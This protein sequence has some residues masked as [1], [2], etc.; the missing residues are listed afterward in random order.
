MVKTSFTLMMNNSIAYIQFPGSNTENE[1]INMIKKCGMTPH[2][3]FWNDNPEDL[4]KYSGYIILGG[5]SFEDRSR[6]GIIASLEPVMDE[7]KKQAQTGKPV[8]G[9]CNGAQILV[10]S[11]MVPGNNNFDTVI[12]LADN[13]RVVRNNI[14]GT[15]YYNTWCYI[16]PN[17]KAN[18][19]FTKSGGDILRVPIAHAEGRF[20]LDKD[21]SDLVMNKNLTTYQYC[22]ENGEVVGDFPVNPNGSFNNAAAISNLSGNVMAMMPH[23][24]RTINGEGNY[25]F[26]NLK[27]YINS[28]EKLSYKSLNF[29]SKKIKV[30]KF[31]QPEDS[32]EVLIST[33]I[34]DNEAL[35]VE[36]CINMLG[37]NVKI[38]KYLHYE[39]IGVSEKEL[40]K[41][42]E[43]DVL[44]NPSKE[45]V[46]NIKRTSS[47][48]HFISRSHDDIHG[49]SLLQTLQTRFSFE[50]LSSLK[51]GVVWEIDFSGDIRKKDV[52]LILNSHI[53]ANPISQV[54]HE[55]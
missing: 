54:C 41:V 51:S 7:I 25:I 29:E 28:S 49:Q 23:P 20:M 11:G 35:S 31:E 3:H 1:T 12:A 30:G 45:F 16:K 55:Y 17:P 39:V 15:G 32:R 37:A 18:S 47:K 6:S 33:I 10:E 8:L 48:K 46:S 38:K 26:E 2:P 34:A 42:L 43:T 5:F 53:F 4:G 19:A 14:V 40:E 50:N 44:F 24:E 27:K 36:K 21:L 9:I 22:K 52:D 13:K